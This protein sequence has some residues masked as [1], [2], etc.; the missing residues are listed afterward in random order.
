[1]MRGNRVP[2][3]NAAVALL[4]IAVVA[5]PS[6]LEAQEA[7]PRVSE[8]PQ[9]GS[10]RRSAGSDTSRVSAFFP[11]GAM[12]LSRKTA[13]A[14]SDPTNRERLLSVSSGT[15]GLFD[16][17]FGES[18]GNPSE[19]ADEGFAAAAADDDNHENARYDEWGAKR[20]IGMALGQVAGINAVVWFFNEYVRG[21]NFTSVNPRSWWF[22]ISHGFFYDDN[23]FKTNMFAH[24][25]HGSLYFNAARSNGMNYFESMPFAVLGS[26]MWECC[27]ETHLPA[28]NDWVM[29]S[30][31][32][33]SIGE[34]LYRAGSTFLDNEKAGG[35]RTMKEIGNFILNPIRGFNRLVS[36]RSGRIYSNP[37]DP[38]D[39]VTPHLHNFLK[40]GVRIRGDRTS[41]ESFESDTTQANMFFEFDMTH[42][43]VFEATRRKPFDFF[44]LGI[45]LNFGDTETVGRLQIHG[46][47]FTSDVSRGEKSHHVFAVTQ[48]YD[49]INN[50]LVEFGGLSYG[51]A[52]FSRWAM[53]ETWDFRTDVNVHFYLLSAVDSEFA[54][55]GGRPPN[56]ERFREYD[57]G[58]GPGAWLNFGFTHS[59]RRVAN[60][61]YRFTYSST[62]NGSNVNGADTY[63]TI[64]WGGF[65]GVFPIGRWGVGADVIA[66]VRR[67]FFDDVGFEDIKQNVGQVRFYGVFQSF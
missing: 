5:A 22:N 52:L 49:Y 4:A 34:V 51:A 10:A 24:P 12:T 53:S 43:N 18:S 32:G 50:N 29:T 19:N 45:Q 46:N 27:G 47:L 28:W 1:M 8:I 62:L 25:Y 37:A 20:N 55:I 11:P 65:Q 30:L 6:V 48:N 36:G 33:A 17:L 23:H 54:F 66:Y 56:V 61:L 59:G 9:G 2:R 13:S 3:V 67:S 58:I 26:F 63:H 21:G 14:A 64:Q 16:E 41:S 38:Y 7:G 44:T 40:L 31:G 60:F 39:R 15:A 35:S 57:F 42:G